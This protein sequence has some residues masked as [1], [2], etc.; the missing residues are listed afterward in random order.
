VTL[1]K[2]LLDKNPM[3]LSTAKIAYKHHQDIPWKTAFDYIGA[4]AGLTQSQD[5][6]KVRKKVLSQF[7]DDKT[8]RPGLEDYKV[9]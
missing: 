6:E 2:V 4:K 5:P 3:V 8:Y 7:V 1:A 9:V